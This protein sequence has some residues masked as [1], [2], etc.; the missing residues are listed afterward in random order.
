[1]NDDLGPPGRNDLDLLGDLVSQWDIGSVL[2]DTDL[3]W[4]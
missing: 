4:M 1:M 2:R 3:H